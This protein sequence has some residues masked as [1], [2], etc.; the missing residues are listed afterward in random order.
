M[1]RDGGRAGVGGSTLTPSPWV[2]AGSRCGSHRHAAPRNCGL[3]TP[4]FQPA[5][6]GKARQMLTDL[7]QIE[8]LRWVEGVREEGRSVKQLSGSKV[9]WP[10]TSAKGA[11]RSSWLSTFRDKKALS[12]I[13][14]VSAAPGLRR[15]DGGQVQF[16]QPQG[17]WP[18]GK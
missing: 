14:F 15:N 5:V 12:G 4:P 13:S 6:K 11:A 1:S 10:F 16:L 7:N 8:K 2:P 9:H 18:G 17:S 3:T